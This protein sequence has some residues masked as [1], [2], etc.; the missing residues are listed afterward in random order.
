[1]IFRSSI[2]KYFII[3]D[4]KLHFLSGLLIYHP[5]KNCFIINNCAG[6]GHTSPI[7]SPYVLFC[8]KQLNL[9]SS[10]TRPVYFKNRS[11]I[12]ENCSSTL[13]FTMSVS[14]IYPNAFTNTP[15]IILSGK[16]VFLIMQWSKPAFTFTSIH[17]VH[18]QFCLLSRSISCVVKFLST[19]MILIFAPKIQKEI[20]N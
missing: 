4:T 2:E 16:R 9:F 7:I 10:S 12:K 19:W 17:Q 15:I 20:N 8:I 6:R 14:N 3:I 18:S 5:M 1:M 13:P 11:R